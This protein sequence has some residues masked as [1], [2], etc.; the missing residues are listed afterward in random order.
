MLARL[1]RTL[2][3][4]LEWECELKLDGYRLEP[5]QSPPPSSPLRMLYGIAD[6]LSRKK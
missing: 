2:P 5:P 3:E 1:A 4:G 6:N